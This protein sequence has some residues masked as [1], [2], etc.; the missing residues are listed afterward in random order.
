METTSALYVTKS[1][2]THRKRNVNLNVVKSKK[3]NKNKH[4]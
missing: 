3:D 4:K 1:V 2:E